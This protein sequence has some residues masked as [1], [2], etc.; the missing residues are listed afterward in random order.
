MS[1]TVNNVANL[2][3]GANLARAANTTIGGGVTSATRASSCVADTSN[4]ANGEILVTDASGYVLRP[5][6][7]GLTGI[8]KVFIVQGQA[9]GKPL[10]RSDAVY[11]AG[12]TAY[13]GKAYTQATEQ[14]DYI[15]YN[16]ATS[17]GSIDVINSNEYVVNVLLRP[18]SFMFGDKLMQ[19]FASYKSDSSATASEI[20]LGLSKNLIL[21]T[22]N[23][24]NI[25]FKVERVNDATTLTAFTGT[26]DA[27]KV[28]KGSTT[29]LFWLA[30]TNAASTG[31]VTA[32]DVINIPTSDGKTY[33]TTVPSTTSGSYVVY[34]GTTAYTTTQVT[35]QTV[36]GTT[37]AA[38][39][40]AGSQAKATSTATTL[41]ITP[42]NGVKFP[43]P[44]VYDGNA[45]AY[46]AVTIATGNAVPTKYRAVGTV[47]A[48]ASFELDQAYQGETGLI[49]DGTTLAT[50]SG[51]ATVIT[52]WGL[53]LTGLPTQFVIGAKR[54]EKSRWATTLQGCGVTDV[55]TASTVANEG[56][57]T[58]EQIAEFEW[59]AQGFLGQLERIQ[60]PP[61]QFIQNVS[62]TGNYSML[63]LGFQEQKGSMI[64]GASPSFKQLYVVGDKVGGFN[65][66]ASSVTNQFGGTTDSSS[67]VVD[68]LDAWLNGLF[69]AQIANV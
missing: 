12:V 9:A 26:S 67:G 43:P 24:P 46:V 56:I 15:G 42:L 16:S 68:T 61:V 39:I 13:V 49:L 18:I 19:I 55:A 25:P 38:A 41:T 35:S 1:Q 28:T 62:A 40:N 5:D 58:Y 21:N 30:S 48:A 59:F 14:V 23:Y 64:L 45:T 66:N 7:T 3:I 44:V 11:R 69:S 53:K 34:L 57:G 51:V 33:T 6:T 36:N 22:Q 2:M 47:S 37:M 10:L 60:V 54:Y 20:A 27:I 65:G 63:F 32:A 50:N 17:S 31:S 52:T 8:D 29:A 4:V